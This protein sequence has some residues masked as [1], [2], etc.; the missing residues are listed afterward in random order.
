MVLALAATWIGFTLYWRGRYEA[1]IERIRAA[2]HPVLPEDVVVPECP[3]AENMLP[4][5]KRAKLRLESLVGGYPGRELFGL[6]SYGGVHIG[7]ATTDEAVRAMLEQLDPYFE[8][9]E[10]AATRPRLVMAREDVPWCGWHLVEQLHERPAI[11]PEYAITDATTLMRMAVAIE[12]KSAS[13]IGVQCDMVDAGLDLL[14]WALARGD[15]IDTSWPRLLERIDPLDRARAELLL[16]RTNFV[17]LIESLKAGEQ[18]HRELDSFEARMEQRG[19]DPPGVLRSDDLRFLLARPLLDRWGASGLG[20]RTDFIEESE[21]RGGEPWTG[22]DGSQG[23]MLRLAAQRL[24]ELT[25]ARFAVAVAIAGEPPRDRGPL[26][27]VETEDGYLIDG[28][29][30]VKTRP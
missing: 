23:R 3:D 11:S 17:E 9:V 28:E 20:R 7:D 21:L 24:E 30:R 27:C 12:P 5:L 25:V 16:E 10:Q 13:Q 18:P 2:G 26:E 14:R 1:E 6:E 4:L 19:Y 8:M 22:R 29:W 15:P